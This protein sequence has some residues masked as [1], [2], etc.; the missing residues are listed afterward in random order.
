MAHP[1]LQSLLI[2]LQKI[3]ES[4]YNFKPLAARPLILDSSL[5][6]GGQDATDDG[7]WLQQENIPGLKKLRESV[8]LDLDVLEK[9]WPAAKS[10]LSSELLTSGY[11]Q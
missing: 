4:L 3:H 7:Q 8:K 10:S 2:R 5:E 9:V 11:L 1:E 6:A